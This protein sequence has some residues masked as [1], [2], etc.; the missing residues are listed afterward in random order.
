MKW[1]LFFLALA[2]PSL[3]NGDTLGSLRSSS[4]V[5]LSTQTAVPCGN[6]GDV[7]INFNGICG[8]VGGGLSGSATGGTSSFGFNNGIIT[9]VTDGSLFVSTFSATELNGF[10]IYASSGSI[11]A[12]TSITITIP[13]TT[14]IW[15]PIATELEG[16][17]TSATSIRIK[18]LSPASYVIYNADALNA[19][20]YIT[21]CFAKWRNS[22]FLY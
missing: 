17:N 13:G 3:A 18:S 20:N 16:V 14:E 22:L 8:G 10:K 1:L 7:Q 9:S 6:S 4:N 11:A 15:F 21:W 19:K 2:V 5:L 12:N